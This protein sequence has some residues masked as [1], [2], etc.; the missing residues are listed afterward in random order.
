MDR[1]SLD[2]LRAIQLLRQCG[3]LMFF[4]IPTMQTRREIL[5]LLIGYQD[6]DS[7]SFIVDDQGVSFTLDDMYI[8]T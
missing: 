1:D 4:A 6:L 8:M 5:E 2:D 7:A 3:L